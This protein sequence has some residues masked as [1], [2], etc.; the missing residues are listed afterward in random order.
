MDEDLSFEDRFAEVPEVATDPETELKKIELLKLAQQGITPP[1]DLATLPMKT[2]LQRM[3][4]APVELP[5]APVVKTPAPVPAPAP[6]PVPEPD[7][8]AAGLEGLKAGFDYAKENNL[9]LH[10]IPINPE[11]EPRAP[12]DI[13]KLSTGQVRPEGFSTE[14]AGRAREVDIRPATADIKKFRG[15]TPEVESAIVKAAKQYGVDPDMLRAFVAIESN[16]DPNSNR[17]KK[18]QYKGLMQIGRDEWSKFGQGDIYNAD[19]NIAAGARLLADNAK[20]FE[21]VMGRPPSPREQYL[22]H[23][24]GLGFYTRGSMTNIGGNLP[25]SA[26]GNPNNWTHQGFENYWGSKLENLMAQAKGAQI[27]GSVP[28]AELAPFM[29]GQPTAQQKPELTGG[30][31]QTPIAAAQTA[32]LMTGTPLEKIK[33]IATLMNERTTAGAIKNVGGQIPRTVRPQRGQGPVEGQLPQEGSVTHTRPDMLPIPGMNEPSALTEALNPS[34]MSTI[35]AYQ[36]GQEGLL[37]RLPAAPEVKA[38]SDIEAEKKPSFIQN[39]MKLATYLGTA[40]SAPVNPLAL[41]SLA[42]KGVT[43]AVRGTLPSIPSMEDVKGVGKGLV[44]G[45][46]QQPTDAAMGTVVPAAAAV[47]LLTGTEGLKD[48]ATEGVQGNEDY[49]AWARGKVGIDPVQ[50]TEAEQA[51][52]FIGRNVNPV[53]AVKTIMSMAG[54]FAGEL[55]QPYISKLAQNYPIQNVLST[56]ANAATVF[57]AP[58]RVI[59]TPGGPVVMN[60]ASL[61]EFVYGG[62]F[63]LGFG[64]APGVA[65]KTANYLKHNPTIAWV[66]NPITKWSDPRRPVPGAPGTVAASLPRDILKGGIVDTS[67]SMVDIADRQA[68]YT[69]GSRVGIDPVVAS[70]VEQRLKIQTGSGVQN[71]TKAAVTVGEVNTEARI[72][73]VPPEATVQNIQKFAT[74]NPD[75][76]YYL[77]ARMIHE[78]LYAN[79]RYNQQ[80]QRSGS[81][82]QPRPRFYDDV[83][84]NRWTLND[85]H[86]TFRAMEAANPEFR[87]VYRDY[88]TNLHE[89]RRFVSEGPNNTEHVQGLTAEAIKRPT[90]PIF[91][92]HEDVM[93]TFG[94]V[95][96]DDSPLAILED[97]MKGAMEKVLK[98]DAHLSYIQQLGTTESFTPRSP[99]WVAQ[100]KHLADKDGS[101]IDFKVNGKKVFYTTDPLLAG[102]IRTGS[103]PLPSQVSRILSGPKRAFTWG[104]TGGGNPMFV[105]T[106][107]NRALWQGMTTAPTGV[108]NARGRLIMPAGPISHATGVVMRLYPQ[109]ARAMVPAA[110]WF[111]QHL[112]NGPLRGMGG[113]N[114]ISRV[115]QQ[116]YERSFYRQ[117]ETAGGFAASQPWEAS[118]SHTRVT[119]LKNQYANTPAAPMMNFLHNASQTWNDFV[120]PYVSGPYRAYN[121]VRAALGD[122][123]FGWMWKAG[124][125]GEPTINGRRISYAELGARGRQ[126]TGDPGV[127][128]SPYTETRRGDPTTLNYQGPGKWRADQYVGLS[129]ALA[130]ARHLVPWMDILIQSPAATVRALKDNPVRAGLAFTATGVLPEMVAYLWNMQQGQEYLDYMMH[131]RTDYQTENFIYV[132]IPGLPPHKGIEVPVNQETIFTRAGTRS[133]MQQWAGLSSQNIYDE[134]NGALLG[135]LGQT[136]IPPAPPGPAGLYTLATGKLVPQGASMF[137]GQ[138]FNGRQNQLD[139]TGNSNLEKALRQWGAGFADIGIHFHDAFSSSPK[140]ATVSEKVGAGA[141]AAGYRAVTKTA[142]VRDIIGYKPAVTGSPELNDE[143][144]AKDR[145]IK[146]VIQV[147]NIWGKRKGGIS[148]KGFGL[149][150]EGTAKVGKFI[151]EPLPRKGDM[152]PNPGLP[153]DLTKNPLWNMTIKEISKTFDEDGTVGYKSMWKNYSTYSQAV[154][155]MYAVNTGNEKEWIREY[156]KENPAMPKFLEKHGVDPQDFRAV[157]DF[158]NLQR[159][160]TGQQILYAIKATEQRINKNPQVRQLLKGKEFK[161]E[162]LNPNKE[163]IDTGEA[164]TP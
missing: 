87:Q 54:S 85:A 75:F 99:Q 16:G 33:A 50:Q 43:D 152:I 106:A 15:F 65:A 79:E 120:K 5:G 118:V 98:N 55:A 114:L 82:A 68:R 4:P 92:Q 84:Q 143:L 66:P 139:A 116:A 102:L 30:L 25:A 27:T 59:N 93:S 76:N 61:S 132:A 62:L 2:P 88:Q 28:M 34:L 112:N 158:Y 137:T 104:A 89:T 72:F 9:P 96:N 134:V 150:P 91:N 23:Q 147:Q 146:D 35:R 161:V 6:A 36:G 67:K 86:Q 108:R 20:R 40:A 42:V 100:N 44:S 123:A 58:P 103:A 22:M 49:K 3:M 115:L 47:G 70:E 157:K 77:K 64:F 125:L 17:T 119:Q 29:G 101:L 7:L 140:E 155:R 131:K 26:K 63:A 39:A 149:K 31:T 48:F 163:G 78:Q 97:K 51:G 154:R 94:R 57:G 156:Y 128:G 136:F 151:A 107:L 127:K 113:T 142:G 12:I 133:F 95:L 21:R 18:T 126:Y 160:K 144:F 13:S 71:L 105:P 141:R 37:P 164:P 1:P 83:A 10:D 53:N 73:K 130:E 52:E 24:Q 121:E 145:F 74:Q 138:S 81:N 60:D 45:A 124:H 69:K 109:M 32:A 122:P 117:I 56:P 110:Q 8:R 41:G 135:F 11:E 14:D 129:K 153:K 90:F 148:T 38:P 162:M 159:Q 111:E 46:L 19:D 80:L